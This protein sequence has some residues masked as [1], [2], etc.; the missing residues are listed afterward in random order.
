[1][2]NTNTIYEIINTNKEE[3]AFLPQDIFSIIL[4]ESYKSTSLL[5]L[6]PDELWEVFSEEQLSYLSYQSLSCLSMDTLE[7][8]EYRFKDSSQTFSVK[9]RI[10]DKEIEVISEPVILRIQ[11]ALNVKKKQKIKL[12]EVARYRHMLLLFNQE[13]ETSYI[14]VDYIKK[15]YMTKDELALS[16]QKHREVIDCQY[17]S[18][19]L[20][21]DVSNQRYLFFIQKKDFL[22]YLES[23]C[24][25]PVKLREIPDI[26]NKKEITLQYQLEYLNRNITQAITNSSMKDRIK[27]YKAKHMLYDYNDLIKLIACIG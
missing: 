21:E 24:S 4:N 9:K 26:R 8:L 15:A 16:M 20:N 19:E 12:K 10:K 17:Q 6:I 2:K 25:H 5:S 18:E 14:P 11:K 1:M 23:I 22:H 27:V 7:M 3:V 13:K